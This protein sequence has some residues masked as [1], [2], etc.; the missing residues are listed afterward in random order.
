M[1]DDLTV[2]QR[3]ALARIHAAVDAREV[4]LADVKRRSADI[5]ARFWALVT[6]EIA[7]GQLAQADVARALGITRETL[8]QRTRHFLPDA[9]ARPTREAAKFLAVGMRLAGER[10]WRATEQNCDGCQTLVIPL[11]TDG[12][13]VHSPYSGRDIEYA[14]REI[15]DTF[16]AVTDCYL[17]TW[18]EALGRRPL[19]MGNAVFAELYGPQLPGSPEWM[20]WQE[21]TAGLDSA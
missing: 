9:P 18:P 1:S 21:R 15:D 2:E 7:T 16:F 17:P 20:T 6:G 13:S 12:L 4:A 14:I 19:F 11:G 5:D 3:A 8:R 10:E